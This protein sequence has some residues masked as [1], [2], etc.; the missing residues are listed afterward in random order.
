M[1]EPESTRQRAEELLRRDRHGDGHGD[2]RGGER[3]VAAELGRLCR[4]VSKVLTLLGAAVTL[5]PDLGAHAVAAAS[6]SAAR[7]LEEAH[8]D[9]GDGPTTDAFSTRRPVLVADLK[10]VGLLRW[11]GWA[12][13]ALEAGVHAVYAFPLLIGATNFGV[14]T[15]YV[16]G[17]APVLDAQGLKNAL[18]YSQIATEIL[19]DGTGSTNGHHLQPDL[20]L[21]LDTHAYVYQAQGM[22][23]VDLAISLAEALARMRAHAWATGQDLTT[24]AA[25]I[26]AG[27][28]RLSRDGH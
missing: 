2:G 19:L 8:F 13:T 28:T 21:V 20:D 6:S 4:V 17:A 16:N 7:R 10:E 18:V 15:L 27:R 14:L 1:S 3:G 11:P 24:L 9:V 23:M 25:E 26:V 5:M 22:V 12:P